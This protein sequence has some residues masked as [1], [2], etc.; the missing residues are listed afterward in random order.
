M[1]VLTDHFPYLVT[2]VGVRMM[3]LLARRLVRFQLTV[4]MYR[5]MLALQDRSEQSLGDLSEMTSVEIS[6]L[7]RLVGVLQR[8][9]L[10]SRTRPETNGRT[11]KISLT[12]PGVTL[13]KQLIPI[14]LRHEDVGL[15]GLK[16]DEIDAVKKYLVNAFHNLDVLE[17]EIEEETRTALES[18]PAGVR[19]GGRRKADR[20]KDD[21]R[22]PRRNAGHS[23]GHA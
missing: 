17:R 12:R 18:R 5:A 23:P 21:R 1:F 9:G 4:P 22:R 8:R 19:R 11:V 2:R 16:A 7:S 6:T 3:D 20:N 14:A 10:V 15:K 13:V